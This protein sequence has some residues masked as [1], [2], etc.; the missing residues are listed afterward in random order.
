M[1]DAANDLLKE[2]ARARRERRPADARRSYEEAV[3][4][5]REEGDPFRL[6]HTLR[7]LGDVLREAG[8]S[9][10]AEPCYRE[11]LAMYRGQEGT[12]P[13]DLA[14]AIRPLAI[15]ETAAGRGREARELWEEARALY[16][17]VGVREGVAE[18]AQQLARL[19]R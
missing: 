17:A 4:L 19:G 8:R 15:L 3:S 11:A 6:A 18:C 12:L 9:S 7:H 2:A 13:L 16:E 10:D 14:N 5:L 1:A